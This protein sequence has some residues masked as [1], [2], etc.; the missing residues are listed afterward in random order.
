MNRKLA[1]FLFLAACHAAPAATT[2]AP[3]ST[4]APAAARDP[5]LDVLDR[6]RDAIE[7]RDA[8]ALA[9]LYAPDA[10]LDTAGAHPV[11]GRD[12]IEADARAEMAPAKVIHSAIARVWLTGDVAIVESVFRVHH[13]KDSPMYDVGESELDVLWFDRGGAIVRE[14]AY[15]DQPTLDAQARG[16]ADGPELPVLP[17]QPEVYT[18]TGAADDATLAWARDAEAKAS[19]SDGDASVYAD[20]LMLDCLPGHF[21]GTSL[22]EFSGAMAAYRKAIPDMRFTPTKMWVVGDYVIMEDVISGTQQGDL[23]GVA[24][25]DKPIAWHWARVWR[26][27]HGK[28]ARGWQWGNFGELYGEI[29]APPAQPGAKPVHPA[30]SVSP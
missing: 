15:R 29:G 6:M 24:A 19:S 1:P 2:A 9:A 30:C 12:A 4:P 5:R 16:D 21:H 8:H 20:D 18:A 25:S 23:D 11:R 3:A 22:A 14:H 27:D 7:A 26:L 13:G 10:E 17:D 28:V